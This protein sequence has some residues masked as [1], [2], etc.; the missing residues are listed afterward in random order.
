MGEHG[1]V[2][3]SP[4]PAPALSSDHVAFG[5]A[6]RELRERKDLSQSALAER[7]G[8]SQPTLSALEHGQRN[9]G[10][11]AVFRLAQQLGVSMVELAEAVERH[12]RAQRKTRG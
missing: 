7:L 5:A 4:K 6:V 12:R 11:D 2:A 1:R 3:R 10:L 9:P 8:T